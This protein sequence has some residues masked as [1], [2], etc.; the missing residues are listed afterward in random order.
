MAEKYSFFDSID[1]DRAYYAADW[2]LHMSKYFTNG[3][4]DN[5]LQVVVNEGMNIAVNSGD[6]NINGY[7][8]NNDSQKVIS[9]A[10]ADG[11]LN[12]IDNI[13]VRLDIPNRQITTEIVTGTFA[14]KAVAPI[15]TRGTSI[16]ELRIAKISIPAGTT[17]ITA[18]LI[19]DTRFDDKDCGN[20]ICAVTNPDFTNILNQYIA[21]WDSL[22]KTQTEDF[23]Q[24]FNEKSAD[25]SSW[26][27]EIKNQLSE[28]AAGNL[29][30]QI[31][32]MRTMLIEAISPV[33]TEDGSYIATESE[34]MIIKG[35]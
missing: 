21:L 2:A 14:E 3:I 33:T 32:E 11:T 28:D 20:V 5:G 27:N 30:L 34:E 23:E 35:M 10:N 29:Q 19:T 25:F 26:F 31:N 22:I 13:V 6:A 16:Y 24:W 9:V 12:R 4:F 8:Y 15:L 18:D 17:E 7:R 1:R